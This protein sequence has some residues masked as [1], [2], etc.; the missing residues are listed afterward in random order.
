MKLLIL[1][2]QNS[3]AGREYLAALQDAGIKIDVASIGEFPEINLAEEERCGGFWKPKVVGTLKAYFSFYSFKSLKDEALSYFLSDKKYD[4]CIQGGTG[5]LKKNIIQQ[6]KIGILNFHPG[7]LPFYRGCS[8]PEWQVYENKPV[9]STV[10][11]VDDGIDT[12]NIIAKK[13]LEIHTESYEELR[14]SIYPQTAKFVVEVVKEIIS[15]G[16]LKNVPEIQDESLAKYR[17]YIGEEKI[18]E[19]KLRYRK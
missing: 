15:Y 7:D 14:A 17:Q 13:I 11:L 4:F 8:A 1:M 5:I 10:H 18:N 2:N 16:G 12:G 19:L 3:Y 6:F 9:I